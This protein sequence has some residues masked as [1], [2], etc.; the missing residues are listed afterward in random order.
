MEGSSRILELPDSYM[1]IQVC[2][3]VFRKDYPN[4]KFPYVR[5]YIVQSSSLSLVRLRGIDN[6]ESGFDASTAQPLNPSGASEYAT[7]AIDPPVEMLRFAG[8]VDWDDRILFPINMLAVFEDSLLIFEIV[9]NPSPRF[10]IE[11]NRQPIGWSYLP[12]SQLASPS[13]PQP[14]D[15]QLFLCKFDRLTGTPRLPHR[16]PACSLDYAWPYR[17]SLPA[18]LS[19]RISF[20][21]SPPPPPP[22]PAPAVSSPSPPLVPAAAAARAAALRAFLAFSPGENWRVPKARLAKIKGGTN[23]VSSI[24]FA[25]SGEWLAFAR[26]FSSPETAEIALFS[27][28]ENK[29]ITLSSAHNGRITSLCFSPDETILVSSS[30]DHSV[31]IFSISAT[32]FGTPLAEAPHSAAVLSI[33]FIGSS[34]FSACRDGGIRGFNPPSPPSYI[35]PCPQSYPT[36]LAAREDLLFSGLDNGQVALIRVERKGIELFLTLESLIET[37]GIVGGHI[38]DL[39]VLRAYD[40][41]LILGENA[42][43]AIDPHSHRGVLSF[44]G[45]VSTPQSSRLSV[46]PDGQ[47]V[48]TGLDNGEVGGWDIATGNPIDLDTMPRFPGGEVRADV[49]EGTALLALAAE[50]SDMP[51]FVYAGKGD[52]KLPF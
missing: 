30:T 16:V 3:C 13:T 5:A 40:L 52:T 27:P 7:A 29:E 39:T 36:C 15:L 34:L 2:E 47:T 38:R 12:L 49:C 23:G 51:L 41:V 37:P 28:I 26:L 4:W 46:S 42:M 14:L 22:A 21:P 44:K 48:L 25:P 20:I 8:R 11:N 9:D 17:H 10:R 24:A 45:G 50:G 1:S 32:N 33:I 31:K 19:L 6:L 43:K 35:K 18:R